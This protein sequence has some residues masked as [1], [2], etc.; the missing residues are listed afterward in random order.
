[1][2]E[3]IT[4]LTQ[5][6]PLEM[7]LA[8]WLDAKSKRSGSAKTLTAYREAITSF[9]ATLRAAGL[10]LDADGRAV[11]LLAQ[12]WAGQPFGDDK[13]R[14]IEPATYNQRLAIL[15]SFYRYAIKQG[16]LEHNPIT[17]VDRRSV[18]GYAHALPLDY[19]ELKAKLAAIDR[20]ELVGQRDY[21]ILAV[22]LQTGRRLSE[23]AA[24]VRGDLK[25]GANGKI[26]VTW[27]RAK[28]GK[29]TV[30][31]LPVAVSKALIEWLGAY[32]KAEIGKLVASTPIWVSLSRRNPGAAITIQTVADICERRL[33]VSKV[34]SL[35]HTFARAMEDS[36]AKVSDIQARLGH[37]SLATT[38]R[39]LAALRRADN[40]HAD[41]LAELFGIE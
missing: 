36:G 7:A 35:R 24:L 23:V 21:A 40:A 20:R 1:M 29:V 3:T 10:D 16:L 4:T 37:T 6:N 39:Y 33:G 25:L 22:A 34:H 41:K 30:D 32:Y 14:L 19:A 15:S 12:G 13:D 38:G 31:T 9:R 11:A 5:Y 27:Q 2:S 26:T 28:G 17:R 18:E 8:A